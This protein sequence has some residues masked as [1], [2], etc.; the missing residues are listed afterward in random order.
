MKKIKCR[1]RTQISFYLCLFVLA[2]CFFSCGCIRLVGKAGYSYQGPH[3]KVP[4]TKQAGFDTQN[5]VQ[6]DRP[7]GNISMGES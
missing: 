6:P 7:R 4:K 5:I 3:D 2:F 1:E